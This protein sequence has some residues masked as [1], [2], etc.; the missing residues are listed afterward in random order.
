M[1][2]RE[3][4]AAIE[5]LES[6]AIVEHFAEDLTMSRKLELTGSMV[7]REILRDTSD[8][9]AASRS[10]ELIRRSQSEMMDIESRASEM[11]EKNPIRFQRRGS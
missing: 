1:S 6:G 8:F 10:A 7:Q 3:R 2:K 11:G 5:E 4:K 9:G